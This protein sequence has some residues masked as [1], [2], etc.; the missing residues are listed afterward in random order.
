MVDHPTAERLPQL[1]IVIESDPRQSVFA[2]IV[3]KPS[4]DLDV[5]ESEQNS[6]R[7]VV[8]LPAAKPDYLQLRFSNLVSR[9]S[10][11]ICG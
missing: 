1:T 5:L 6:L 2:L 11:R 8:G 10:A 9:L 4:L 7:R 3:E